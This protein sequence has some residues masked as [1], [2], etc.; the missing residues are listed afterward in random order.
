MS[1]G[2]RSYEMARRLVSMGHEANIITSWREE[3]GRKGWFET[4]ESGIRVHWLPVPYS[5]H[6]SYGDR[7]R[8]FSRFALGSA[9]KAASIPSDVI[10]A[11]STPLTIALP[12]VYASRRRKVPMVFEV[13]D[14]WPELPIAMGALRNPVLRWGAQW[15]ERYAYRNARS[16][17]ALSPGMQEGVERAGFPA[18]RIAM[19]PNSC[20]LA[21]FRP[22]PSRGRA[23]REQHGIPQD[24]ILV[25][26]GGTFGRINGV[27]YLARVAHELLDD[28][29]FH[30]LLVGAGQERQKVEVLASEMRLLGR[31][32]T[33]LPK[34]TK[35]EMAEVL[36]ATD[37]ATSLFIPLPEMEAN[38]ANKFFD[39][40]AAGCSMAVNYG[41]WHQELL[42]SSGAGIRLDRDPKLAAR[43]LQEYA[44]DRERIAQAGERARVLAEERF[45]RDL[46]AQE[47]E[48]VLVSAVK[49]PRS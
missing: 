35:L 10:F 4:D 11:T 39:G 30:F 20:D 14:L 49:E 46:L 12:G 6:M 43:T 37:I 5:N 45:S 21:H 27:D 47:L 17:V 38:S 24:S 7:I 23:F 9:R 28:E 18:E 31:R 44:G 34:V 22:D 15:L 2:T 33:L 26:Y 36:A 16:I 25:T 8:A 41:G 1:G 42:E 19:I 40:L 29:R 3:D 48:Q 13:R 32:L